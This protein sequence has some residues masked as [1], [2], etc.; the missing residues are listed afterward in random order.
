MS[1][2]NGQLL[3]VHVHS[4]YVIHILYIDPHFVHVCMKVSSVLGYNVMLYM[5]EHMVSRCS[6]CSHISDRIL[7]VTSSRYVSFGDGV[8]ASFHSRFNLMLKLGLSEKSL[9]LEQL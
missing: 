1:S 7:L 2:K 6:R 8:I 5:Y 4:T 3:S 9:D